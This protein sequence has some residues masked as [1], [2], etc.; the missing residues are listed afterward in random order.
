[1]L[2]TK[3]DNIHLSVIQHHIVIRLERMPC[4]SITSANNQGALVNR[5]PIFKIMKS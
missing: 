4:P 3:P 1:M 2:I 5:A